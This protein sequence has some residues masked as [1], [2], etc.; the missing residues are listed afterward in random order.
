VIPPFSAEHCGAP[1]ADCTHWHVGESTHMLGIDT[2]LDEPM[3][4]YWD[5][6]SQC[7]EPHGN[8]PISAASKG[9]APSGGENPA[10]GNGGSAASSD[11][12]PASGNGGN[13]ASMSGNGGNAASKLKSGK[14]ESGEAAGGGAVGA[15]FGAGGFAAGGAP[16]GDPGGASGGEPGGP[17]AAPGWPWSGAVAFGGSA[18]A[19]AFV[20]A[21]LGLPPL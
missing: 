20:G 5:F 2:H 14:P 19:L 1:V 4:Q 12:S 13:A 15:G 10:S 16:G 3:S 6:A 11:G 17:E 7:A 21:G 8:C 9:S 18:C